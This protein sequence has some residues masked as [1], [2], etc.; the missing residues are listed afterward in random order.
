MT[1]ASDTSAARLGGVPQ[2][3]SASDV[4]ALTWVQE[5]VRRSLEASQKA[6]QRHLREAQALSGSD[7]DRVDPG[8]LR[9]ARTHLH[10]AAGALEL[11]GLPVAARV[12]RAGEQ[13]VQRMAERPALLTAERLGA[14]DAAWAALSAALNRLTLGRPVSA[15]S[16]FPHYRGL[17]ECAGAERIH[18]ADLWEAE[19]RWRTI[20]REGGLEVA[21]SEAQ[22][23]DAMER[24]VLRLMRAPDRATLRRMSDL[25][26]TL[27]A[28]A[29][30]RVATLWRLAAGF[31]EA[32]A[33][34]LLRWDAYVKRTA[35]RLLA[36]ARSDAH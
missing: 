3:T 8:V 7:V 14:M 27:G 24:L 22:A 11:V 2:E 19:W 33:Q 32:Q 12:V 17:L 34:G 25:C 35:P 21:L 30:G 16:L 23:R 5:E 26:A 1:A 15:V 29:K 10:Q 28:D 4:R 9:A 13:A 20:T 36:V 18:P 6:L 31:F